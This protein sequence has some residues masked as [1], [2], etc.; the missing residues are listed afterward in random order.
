MNDLEKHLIEQ[1]PIQE[2][3]ADLLSPG[4]KK[5]GEAL[6]TVLDGA[7]LILLPLKLLNAKSKVF[8]KHNIDRYSDKLNANQNLKLTNVPQYVGLPIIE[9]LTYLDQNDLSEAF[10]NLLTK[11]SF[12]ETLKLVH[13]TYISILNNLSADEAKILMYF[14]D[15]NSIPFIDINLHKYYK[16][17]EEL[18]KEGKKSREEL[19][20]MINYTFKDKQ[21]TN[22]NAAW[23]LTGIEKEIELLFPENID[24]YLENLEFNG[25]LKFKRGH[26]LES[27]SE[28]Y[29]ELTKTYA[30]TY[31]KLENGIKEIE[32]GDLK[33]ELNTVKCIIEFTELGKGFLNACVRDLE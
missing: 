32:E 29:E 25:L 9:K 28:K 31:S 16:K 14:K 23:N 30:E 4:M 22:L 12:E 17:P 2:L 8:F 1:I 15:S 26:Y 27:Y 19:K 6:E 21:S 10:I 18:N 13:P 20:Q 3:Y 33:A 5:A 7:N 24:I 11:A